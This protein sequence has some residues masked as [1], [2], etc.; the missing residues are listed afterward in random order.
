[1]CSV[2]EQ[3]FTNIAAP[4]K[5]KLYNQK[6]KSKYGWGVGLALFE[7]SWKCQAGYVWPFEKLHKNE[8]EVQWRPL[9]SKLACSR[10]FKVYIV[11]LLSKRPLKITIF[12][13]FVKYVPSS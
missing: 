1:M 3:K 5:T 2:V 7:K 13:N 8:F 10:P 12:H 11:T 9:S 4:R 6:Y